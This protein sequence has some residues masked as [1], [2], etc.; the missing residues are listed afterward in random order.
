MVNWSLLYLISEWSI[1]IAMLIYVPQKRS[2]AASRTWLL[3]IFLLPWPGLILYGLFGRIYVPARRIAMQ[4]RVS[5]YLRLA[6]SQIGSSLAVEPKLAPNL[7][8]IP[9]EASRLGDFEALGGNQIDLLPEYVP[10]LQ[11][12]LD[13]IAAARHHVHLLFYIYEGDATGARMFKALEAAV[14]RGVCCRVL[15]D[16]FG[17]K[18][19]LRVFRHAMREA[20]IEVVELLPVGPFRKNAARF[21]L[22]NHRKIAVID[23]R[24]GYTGSQNIV[25]PAF[26]PGYPNEELLVRIVGP[27]VAQLQAVFLADHYFETSKV[28]REPD[29]FPEQKSAGATIAQLVPSGPGYGRENGRDLIVSM[30]YMARRTATITTPYFVP[31]EPFLHAIRAAA[32]GGVEVRLVLSQHA[33]QLVTQLAQRSFYDDLLDAGVEIYLYR[34]RFLHAKHVTIDNEIALV[35]STNMDIRSFALNSEINLLIYSP[36][37]VA[38]LRSIQ[39]KYFENSEKLSATTWKKRPFGSRVIQNTARLMDSF[40]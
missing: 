22:R 27:A 17:S 36:R 13:D 7:Q 9:A 40:L 34:P 2:A 14:R 18:R 12:L 38:D 37:I 29:L 33:N 6:Q 28:L 15:L 39:Q 26:V 35:G 32:N 16:A 4:Q 23:G 25:D 30:L 21:D 31:D 8:P 5:H 20:G 3:F 24:I 19:G 10:A 1:R 11:A